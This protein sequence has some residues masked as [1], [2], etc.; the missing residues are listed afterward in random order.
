MKAIRGDSFRNTEK[1]GLGNLELTVHTEVKKNRKAA[2]NLLDRFEQMAG[3]ASNV[4]RGI[5][6]KQKLLRAIFYCPFLV[7]RERG[8]R[9]EGR[10]RERN[11][12]TKFFVMLL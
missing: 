6:K 5:K 1:E 4:S 9:E 8:K 3:G 7:Q 11:I 2:C 10:D 12:R